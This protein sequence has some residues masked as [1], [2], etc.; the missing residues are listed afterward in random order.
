MGIIDEIRGRRTT[1]NPRAD[2]VGYRQSITGAVWTTVAAALDSLLAAAAVGYARWDTANKRLSMTQSATFPPGNAGMLEFRLGPTDS[3]FCLVYD[4]DGYLPY[5]FDRNGFLACSGHNIG[6][7]VVVQNVIDFA[8]IAGSNGATLGHF[9]GKGPNTLGN[10]QTYGYMLLRGDDLNA[11]SMD[12][13]WRIGVMR[14]VADPNDGSFL[15]PNVF[16]DFTPT[17]LIIPTGSTL[18][19]AN[20]VLLSLSAFVTR[21]LIIHAVPAS[22][23]ADINFVA[24]SAS[25]WLDES[26][27]S[28]KFKVKDSGGTIK[29][30]I[31][32]FARPRFDVTEYGAKIDGTTDDSTAVNAAG[33]AASAVGGEV[34]FPPGTCVAENVTLYSNVRYNGVFGASILKLKASSSS[35]FLLRGSGASGLMGGSGTGGIVNTV[36]ENLILDGNKANNTTGVGIQ[37]YG[38]GYTFRNLI[39]RNFDQDGIYSDWNGGQGFGQDGPEAQYDNVKVHDCDGQGVR[40]AGPHDTKFSNIV[41]DRNNLNLYVGPNAVACQFENFHSWSPTTQGVVV[42]GGYS[43][44]ANAAIEGAGGDR[45]NF[46]MLG[47]GGTM[48]G[49]H[50]YGTDGAGSESATGLQLG[51]SGTT[52]Y[53]SGAGAVTVTGAKQATGLHINAAF[54]NCGG[55]SG[56]INF[57]SEANNT[58]ICRLFQNSGT[59]TNGTP[60]N[61]TSYALEVSGLVA[62]GTLALS[63]GRKLAVKSN[64]AFFVTDVAGTDTFNVNSN[65]GKVEVPNNKKLFLYSSGYSANTCIGLNGDGSQ[66]IGWNNSSGTFDAFIS[67]AAGGVVKS[68]GTF[69]D[70]GVNNAGA[71]ASS[72]TLAVTVS[73]NAVGTIRTQPAAAVTGIIL[74]VGSTNGQRVTVF[75]ESAAANTITFAASGT[76]NVADGTGDVIAGLTA[77]TFVWNASTSL[78]YPAK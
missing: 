36:V 33:T 67:R 12:S 50:F 48:A 24:N 43:Q 49:V 31:V 52:T 66:G 32:P 47:G 65:S 64:Q 34:Y 16:Y 54:D 28:L 2:Q 29:T 74:A 44:W 76:S 58:L 39:V 27:N 60:S 21:G 71:I 9:A 53:G 42:E 35:G 8:L 69:A 59:Y 15:Q 37:L 23:L 72:A 13:T 11:A 55:A 77:R 46:V 57:V 38:Y 4:K 78:W 56:A 1:N 51:Q 40:F 62:D 18:E 22:E 3:Y 30:A 7:V 5:S 10:Y 19:G 73:S 17:A 70:A 6:G 41:L 75:N 68:N 25:P 45:A 14:A 20:G 63:G 26:L 61:S